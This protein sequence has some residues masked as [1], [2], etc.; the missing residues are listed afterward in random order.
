MTS[1]QKPRI[2]HRSMWKQQSILTFAHIANQLQDSDLDPTFSKYYLPRHN[3]MPH[4]YK[5][6]AHTYT[7][8][9]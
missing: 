8:V 1:K 9:A 6:C 7:Y 2:V 5:P 3:A 4:I